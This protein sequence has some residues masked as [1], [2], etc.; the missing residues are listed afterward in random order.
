LATVKSDHA[1][2]AAAFLLPLVLVSVAGWFAWSETW[3][4][5]ESELHRTA[6]AAAEYAQRLLSS[7]LLAGRLT[8]S[9]LAGATDQEIRQNEAL[10]HSR[11]AQIMPD[12]PDAI[13]IN[14]SDR[15]GLLI[16]MSAEYPVPQVSVADREWVQVLRA[17]DAPALFVGG[18]AT[19]RVQGRL[20]FNASIPRSG[21]GNEVPAGSY[22][23]LVSISLDPYAVAVDLAGST[24]EPT[25]V[26]AL[27]RSDG[28]ILTTTRGLRP[29]MPRIPAES[30]LLAK[31]EAGETAGIYEGRALGLRE[32]VP[33]GRGL[34][35]AFRQVGELPV[36]VTVSRTPAAIV[37]PWLRTM[38]WLLAVGLPASLALGFMSLTA[39]R[40]R[41][42]LSES[43]AELAASFDSAA[44]GTALVEAG[45]GRMLKVNRRLCDLT[46]RE[47]RELKRMTLDQ[48]LERGRSEAGDAAAGLDRLHR[49]D[50]TVRWVECATAPVIRRGGDAPALLVA[51]LH[52]ITERME[53]QER[54]TLLAREVDH[55]AKNV[56]AIVQ[57]VIR[58]GRDPEA[59]HFADKIEGRI[60]A[61][62]RAHELLARDRWH[63]ADL[64][65]LI[66]DELSAYQDGA[67]VTIS[68]S[69]VRIAPVA[70]QPLSMA[71]HELA[72]N[73][74]KHGVLGRTDGALSISWHQSATDGRL[75]VQWQEQGARAAQLEP[76]GHGAGLKIL[77]GSVEQLHGTVALDWREEG[78]S[79]SIDLPVEAL[80]ARPAADTGEES[81]S[82]DQH[83]PLAARTLVG[84]RVLVVEDEA[85]VAMD[86]KEMLTNLGCTVIGPAFSVDAARVLA[87]REAGQLD[88]AILDANLHGFTTFDVARQ[89]QGDGT[90]C[91]FVTGYSELPETAEKDW[92]LLRKPVNEAE[93]AAA[94][95]RALDRVSPRSK[96]SVAANT[97]LVGSS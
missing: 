28:E 43:R 25:D 95:Q 91:V 35:I 34:S 65:D 85:I 56:L 61:L 69:A 92:V 19:S 73:A 68:G 40:R 67:R 20:F 22:D 74:V 90:A 16:L 26:I 83:A 94:L 59:G 62:A 57:A 88:A 41:N 1:Q 3:E 30:R 77:R 42:A 84:A 80:V 39:V 81:R 23:G 37:A 11:L 64:V 24:H 10:F 60:K 32:G 53:S 63:G 17:P 7:A 75:R 55:R 66:R 49:P 50:G 58:L 54:Q 8:N 97:E 47:A 93:I 48:L 31:I 33:L 87:T 51:T 29:E 13:T 5:A 82:A 71:L 45:S 96:R 38:A 89:L 44:T 76:K 15:D 9:L 72:T 70:V 14:V 86:L 79:C 52:D 2:V 21:S 4:R 36:Y 18:L 27:V 46:G 6:D 12:L 78:L